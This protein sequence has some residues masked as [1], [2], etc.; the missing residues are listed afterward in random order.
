MA[1]LHL[2]LILFIDLCWALNIVAVKVAV[3][4]VDPLATAALR[5]LIV[6]LVCLPFIRWVP[7]RMGR[8]VLTGLIAGAL[9]M[10]C[11]NL[12]MA[13]TENV[14][15]LAIAGQVGVPFSL[16][17]AVVFLGERIRWIRIT[18]TALAIVGI[19]IMGFDPAI[20]AERLGVAITVMASF[21]W[22]VGSL[23]FRKLEGIHVLNIHGWLALVSFPVLAAASWAFEPRALASLGEVPLHIFGWIAF[24]AIFS[25][26]VGHAGMTW[27][28]QR[29]DVQTIV[30]LTLPTP[31]LSATFAVIWF[32]TPVTT[33]LIV[34]ALV[35][36]VGVAIITLRSAQKEPELTEEFVARPRR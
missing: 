9:F 26:I 4:V 27:L 3:D 28:L 29:Y 18:G 36:F 17:L 13:V 2:A 15:A 5:Y 31:L 35:S 7:G 21:L 22:A 25:S 14:A 33:G 34:G 30:P 20:W 24:S 19:V 32:G 8:I 12:S 1:P 6:F 10:L 11:T 16:I 23:L